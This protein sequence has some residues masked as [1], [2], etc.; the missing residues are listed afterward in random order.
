MANFLYLVIKSKYVVF[1]LV[2]H[3]EINAINF[4]H[5]VNPYIITSSLKNE[6]E[7]F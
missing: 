4:V 7:K 5:D 6:G 1:V 2:P 3:H